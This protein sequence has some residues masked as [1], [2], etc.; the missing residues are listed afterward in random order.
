MAAGGDS[1]SRWFIG[2]GALAEGDALTADEHGKAERRAV[3]RGGL[4]EG[5][6]SSET[7]V[8]ERARRCFV[9]LEWRQAAGTGQGADKQNAALQL[10][11]GRPGGLTHANTARKRQSER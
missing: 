4:E 7:V 11:T 8:A 3:S 10:G 6:G 1:P 9:S 5:R 2:P